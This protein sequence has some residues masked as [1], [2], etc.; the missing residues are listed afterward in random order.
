MSL[1]RKK[2]N[3]DKIIFITTFN[4]VS[5]KSVSEVITQIGDAYHNNFTA[6]S[7]TNTNLIL[8][9][10]AC[11]SETG[12][13]KTWDHFSPLFLW[14]ESW[15]LTCHACWWIKREEEAYEPSLFT[16]WRAPRSF[17]LIILKDS[18]NSLLSELSAL[19]IYLCGHMCFLGVFQCFDQL[20]VWIQCLSHHG[21]H[22]QLEHSSKTSMPLSLWHLHTFLICP[23][24]SRIQGLKCE[25]NMVTN[26]TCPVCSNELWRAFI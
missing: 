18:G 25:N 15:F 21:H 4:L 22:P 7:P 8:Q 14:T 13:L 19:S 20:G 6:K 17:M 3:Y 10:D 1:W 26:Y 23:V 2:L 24:Q 9:F 16:Q 5:K 12:I 11:F